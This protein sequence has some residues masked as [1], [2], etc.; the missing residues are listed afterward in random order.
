MSKKKNE[1]GNWMDALRGLTRI[2]KDEYGNG[3]KLPPV[4]EMARRLNVAEN[5]YCKALRAICRHGLAHASQGRAGTVIL[6]E[7]VRRLKIGLLSQEVNPLLPAFPL[8]FLL[9]KMLAKGYLLQILYN[10]PPDKLRERILILNISALFVVNPPSAFYPVLAELHRSGFPLVIVEYYNYGVIEQAAKFNLPYFYTDPESL[11]MSVFAFADSIQ[12]ETVLQIDS[13]P[14]ILTRAFE[15]TAVVSG[16]IFNENHFFPFSRIENGLT[17][18]I[19]KQKIEMI[20]AKCNEFHAEAICE[21]IRLLP[22]SK[23]PAL[24]FSKEVKPYLHP[25]LCKGVRIAGYFDFDSNTYNLAVKKFL[26]AVDENRAVLPETNHRFEIISA[27][28]K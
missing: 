3:G 22:E 17:T 10:T 13:K 4:P 5:T 28:F 1:S 8:S 9:P 20:Y 18:R 27:L 15:K 19:K 7:K 14:T 24:V 21:Q 12:A 23:R 11:A 6:P 2:I 16:R 25:R 26:E